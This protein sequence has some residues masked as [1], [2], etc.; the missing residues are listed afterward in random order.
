MSKTETYILGIDPGRHKTGV[1]VVDERGDVVWRNVIPTS[2]NYAS[3]VELLQKWP[4]TRVALGH[5]T[6][7]KEAE[8]IIQ[9]ILEEQGSTATVEIINERESTLEARGLYFEAHPPRGWRRLVPLSLQTPPVPVDD[10]AAVVLA[11]RAQA[12]GAASS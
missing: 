7:S 4:I 1:A 9:L 11:R 8:K 10:F 12:G 5:S 2:D 6:G 3:L